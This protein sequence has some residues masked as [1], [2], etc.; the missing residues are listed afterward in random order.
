MFAGLHPNSPI[1]CHRA[2]LRESIEAADNP[3]EFSA[4]RGFIGE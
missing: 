3:L 1:S 4:Y 2:L